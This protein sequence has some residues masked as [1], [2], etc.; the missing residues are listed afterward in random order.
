[1]PEQR[2]LDFGEY[3]EETEENFDPIDE[4]IWYCTDDCGRWGRYRHKCKFAYGIKP[5]H[6][7]GS[8][9]REDLEGDEIRLNSYCKGAGGTRSMT[10]R[11][12]ALFEPNPAS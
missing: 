5:M 2:E 10:L 4:V 1:M 12:E 3:P 8:F 11:K 6:V 9:T 7:S